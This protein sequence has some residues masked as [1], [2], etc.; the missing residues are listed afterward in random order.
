[1]PFKIS[2]WDNYCKLWDKYCKCVVPCTLLF[3]FIIFFLTATTTAR[4]SV[5]HPWMASLYSGWSLQCSPTIKVIGTICSAPVAQVCH[6]MWV[7][8]LR[9]PIKCKLAGQAGRQWWRNATCN[10]Q[11]AK[12]W[13]LPTWGKAQLSTAAVAWMREKGRWHRWQNLFH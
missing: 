10:T 5:S 2:K 13:W 9:R 1:M 12:L 6:V 7:P 4:L 8:L 11:T 3:F